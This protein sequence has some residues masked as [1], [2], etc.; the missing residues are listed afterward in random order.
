MCEHL[1]ESSTQEK[2][3]SSGC[4]IQLGVVAAASRDSASSTADR[5]LCGSKLSDRLW[6]GS[7]LEPHRLDVDCPRIADESAEIL[8]YRRLSW[9][10][11]RRR[12]GASGGRAIAPHPRVRGGAAQDSSADRQRLPGWVRRDADGRSASCQLLGHPVSALFL[13]TCSRD[14]TNS[15][16]GCRPRGPRPGKLLVPMQAPQERSP[17]AVF[18]TI[19][20]FRSWATR[21]TS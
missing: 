9:P 20:V 17:E 10:L 8:A 1:S 16:L 2:V 3:R 5:P 19:P 18:P 14:P 15:G 6:P 12:A 11:R 7:A 13:L 4:G 21:R